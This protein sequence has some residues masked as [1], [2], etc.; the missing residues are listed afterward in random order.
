MLMLQKCVHGWP[1]CG[2]LKAVGRS[3]AGWGPGGLQ[4]LVSAP[5]M[6]SRL[7]NVWLYLNKAV[8]RSVGRQL[9]PKRSA[10]IC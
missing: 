7:A 4:S 10:I 2:Y 3:V 5:K 1:T 9:M 8:G 6:R